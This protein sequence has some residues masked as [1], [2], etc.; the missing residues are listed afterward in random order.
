[1]GRPEGRKKSP[2]LKQRER[3]KGSLED[4][5]EKE[6]D[7]KGEG[8]LFVWIEKG[9]YGI[10]NWNQRVSCVIA[11]PNQTVCDRAGDSKDRYTQP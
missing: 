3:G 10:G 2:Q 9:E 4:I 11:L 8:I 6:R 7:K 1:M 5:S